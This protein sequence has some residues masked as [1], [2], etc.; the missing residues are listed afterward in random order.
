GQDPIAPPKCLL[1][2]RRHLNS[3]TAVARNCPAVSSS[4]ASAR[5]RCRSALQQGVVGLPDPTN[6]SPTSTSSTER[7]KLCTCHLLLAGFA[8][9]SC[10]HHHPRCYCQVS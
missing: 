4:A 6:A 9:P 2:L 5:S 10:M 7:L 3:C 8:S 1:S